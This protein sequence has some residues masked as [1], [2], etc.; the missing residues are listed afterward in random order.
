MQRAL[1]LSLSLAR[2]YKCDE[3]NTNIET[4]TG[5]RNRASPGLPRA[6][7]LSILAQRRIKDPLA[8]G[9]RLASVAIVLVISITVKWKSISRS[10]TVLRVAY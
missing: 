3:G 2:A 7:V 6:E 10:R 4:I 1:A 8:S 9:G 5:L